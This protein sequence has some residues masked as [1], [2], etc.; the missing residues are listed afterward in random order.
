MSNP[1][2]EGAQSLGTTTETNEFA[3]LLQQDDT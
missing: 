3:A 1:S 2:Q